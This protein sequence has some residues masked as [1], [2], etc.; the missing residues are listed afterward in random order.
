MKGDKYHGVENKSSDNVLLSYKM[1]DDNLHGY[2][3]KFLNNIKYILYEFKDSQQGFTF[4]FIEIAGEYI[5][6]R[7]YSLNDEVSNHL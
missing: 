6:Y 1:F 7:V 2:Q 5:P 4:D 3:I